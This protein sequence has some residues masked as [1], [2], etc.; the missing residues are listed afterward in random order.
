MTSQPRTLLVGG[1]VLLALAGALHLTLRLT[2]G[3][4]SAY[5]HVRWAPSVDEATRT[6]VERAHSLVPVEFR[7]KRTWGYYLTDLST[8]NIRQLVR[9]PAVEDT[10]NIDRARFRV[11]SSAERGDYPRGRPVWMAR[12]LEFLIRV[13]L[14]AGAAGVVVGAFRTWR[15]RRARLR[16]SPTA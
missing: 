12:L 10:H 6:R 9:D 7:E 16:S 11:Q 1:V 5:V 15:D 2:Y 4:R 3:E 8:D 13:S 14:L